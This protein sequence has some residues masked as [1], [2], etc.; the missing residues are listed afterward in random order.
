[1]H[2]LLRTV[3]LDRTYY[4]SIDEETYRRYAE[5]V[6]RDFRFLVKADRL[7]TSPTDPDRF[8]ARGVNPHF[9]DPR[10]AVEEVLTPMLEGLTSKVGPILFQFPPIPPNLIGGVR[11]FHDRL[12][13]FLDALPDGPTYAVEL[14]TPEFLNDE[15]ASLLQATG[16][17][18]AKALVEIALS[19]PVVIGIGG[20]TPKQHHL[21]EIHLALLHAGVP[22][23]LIEGTS[24]VSAALNQGDG[25]VMA[26]AETW[27]AAFERRGLHPRL[28]QE[29]L[30]H[31]PAGG[32]TL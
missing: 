20:G 1:M 15:Y 12:Y 26:A 19:H 9:L 29:M 8:G 13:R 23:L 17:T 2:P 30:G 7:L 27:L 28:S 10:R 18:S 31:Q 4:R 25:G 3:G 32:G 5:A 6:P 24:L 11:R 22:H 14:R 16:E 21:V